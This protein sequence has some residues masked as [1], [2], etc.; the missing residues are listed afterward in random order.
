MGWNL[1]LQKNMGESNKK[2]DNLNGRDVAAIYISVTWLLVKQ[3]EYVWLIYNDYF[4]SRQKVLKILV[5]RC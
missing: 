5:G 3:I 2:D 1:G 4:D